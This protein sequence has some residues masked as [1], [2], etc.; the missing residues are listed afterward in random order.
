MTRATRAR[1]HK[2]WFTDYATMG[3]GTSPTLGDVA[4]KVPIS[5]GSGV[6]FASP[7][8]SF[9]GEDSFSVCVSIIRHEQAF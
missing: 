7:L 1:E 4:S 9:T 5:T 8:G 2:V 6:P 3:T